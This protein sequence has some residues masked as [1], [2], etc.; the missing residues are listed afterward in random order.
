MA[1]PFGEAMI[2]THEN[3]PDSLLL[4][5]SWWTSTPAAFPGFWV[6]WWSYSLWGRETE[7]RIE[8]FL[9]PPGNYSRGVRG[10]VIFGKGFEKSR[11]TMWRKGNPNT[12]KMQTLFWDTRETDNQIKGKEAKYQQVA[13]NIMGWESERK[14]LVF[15]VWDMT[16][17]AWLPFLFSIKYSHTIMP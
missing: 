16:R 7:L 2:P 1:L 9:F 17:G 5:R 13:V 11:M 14:G 15:P 6:L 8:Y 12:G 10:S 3:Q 4:R